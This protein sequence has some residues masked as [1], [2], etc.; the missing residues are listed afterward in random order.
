MDGI[1]IN[2]VSPVRTTGPVGGAARAGSDT[3]DAIRADALALGGAAPN[4]TAGA[5]PGLPSNIAG[6]ADRILQD[7]AAAQLAGD[8]QHAQQLSNYATAMQALT[9]NPTAAGLMAQAYLNPNASDG[10]KRIAN[11]FLGQDATPTAWL[12]G[13]LAFDG[14][15]SQQYRASLPNN[16]FN[17]GVTGAQLA[18][19]LLT[20]LSDPS[21]A[22]QGNRQTC[23]ATTVQGIL[24]DQAPKEYMRIATTL[25]VY[26]NCTLASGKVI[27]RTSDW[28]YAG[29]G[30][31]SLPGRLM[32]PAFMADSDGGSYN[33]VADA[34]NADQH[35]GTS[36]AEMQKLLTDVI[37]AP[38][39]TV[40]TK[41]FDAR[42]QAWVDQGAGDQLGPIE[43]QLARGVEVPVM[44]TL[45]P[46]Q[47]FGH[48][49]RVQSIQGNVV[50]C[51]NPWGY[52][53]NMTVDQFR[54]RLIAA[55]YL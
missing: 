28:N 32:Q 54:Q 53:E 7:A 40:V 3:L 51:I 15:S 35:K 30:N 11:L 41:N 4:P 50:T 38:T 8:V 42:Q 19:D 20:E 33:N 55:F 14:P 13:I 37:N 26:G 39:N 49:E 1:S 12:V 36:A 34:S 44:L 23:G 45:N 25:A 18:G 48:Y 5:A 27:Q 17:N 9:G 22:F 47:N 52:P 6:V 29:D 31:R 43:Q 2:R 24:A 10:A 21:K 16:I 46:N